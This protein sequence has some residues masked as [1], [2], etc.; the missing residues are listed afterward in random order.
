LAVYPEA[1][2][3]GL[4]EVAGVVLHPSAPAIGKPAARRI[5]I[6]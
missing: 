1:T 5:G 3:T 2:V 4:D 6:S